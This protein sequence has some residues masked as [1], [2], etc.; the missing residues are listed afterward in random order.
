[1]M[2]MMMKAIGTWDGFDEQPG[3]TVDGDD[4]DDDKDDVDDNNCFLVQKLL[5]I[6]C[7]SQKSDK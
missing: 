2:M 5:P 6:P 3:Y 7:G 4:D 1:M